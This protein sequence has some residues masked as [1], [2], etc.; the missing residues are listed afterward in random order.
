MDISKIYFATTQ[1]VSGKTNRDV[2]KFEGFTDITFSFY[3][4]ALVLQTKPYRFTD[5]RTGEVFKLRCDKIPKLGDKV[6]DLEKSI[7]YSK[8]VTDASSCDT[9]EEVIRKADMV[10]INREGDNA[11]FSYKPIEKIYVSVSYSKI[12]DIHCLIRE[13]YNNNLV[14][15]N[16]EFRKYIKED[17]ESERYLLI[18]IKGQDAFN[19]LNNI[20]FEILNISKNL[21][22]LDEY[23]NDVEQQKQKRIKR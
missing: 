1:Y 15:N 2:N 21:D 12:L 18:E 17:N 14:I 11:V 6:V 10:Q 13:L 5:L 22:D 16:Y 9:K 19:I 23:K 3:K 8:V 4:I 20:D 7:P